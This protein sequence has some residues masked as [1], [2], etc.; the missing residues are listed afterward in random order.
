MSSASTRFMRLRWSDGS[1]MTKSRPTGVRSPSRR[2][3]RVQKLWKVLTHICSS[4]TETSRWIRSRIS[5]AALLVKVIARMAVGLTP[6]SSMS[7]A[8]RRVMTVV[9]PDPAPARI[10]SGPS[11]WVTA[12][13]WG[14]FRLAS[15][16]SLES[17]ACIIP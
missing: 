15:N 9:L 11:P 1:K 16:S 5:S 17:P 7:Q 4:G 8:M 6:R 2:K 10:S 3:T 13:R 12:N 14:G